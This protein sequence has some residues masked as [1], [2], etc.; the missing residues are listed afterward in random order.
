MGVGAFIVMFSTSWWIIFY[1]SLPIGTKVGE[2]QKGHADSAPENPRIKTKLVVTT[3]LSLLITLLFL[4]L[5]NI[6]VIDL[7]GYFTGHNK[8]LFNF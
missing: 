6:K 2:I 8:N 7:E 1:I 5:V 4:H 3:I